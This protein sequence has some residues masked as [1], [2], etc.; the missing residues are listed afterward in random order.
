MDIITKPISFLFGQNPLLTITTG[1]LSVYFY[2]QK[3]GRKISCFMNI[4]GKIGETEKIVSLTLINEKDK[5]EAIFMV[6]FCVD[7]TMYKLK[8]FDPPL[9][10]KAN[11]AVT[12]IPDDVTYYV[13]NNHPINM[14]KILPTEGTVNIYL[15]MSGKLYRCR[16]PK[17]SSSETY[18]LEKN[19]EIGGSFSQFINN[20]IVPK[21][22]KFSITYTINNKQKTSFI[23]KN[24]YITWGYFPNVIPQ[25]LLNN[26]I[27]IETTLQNSSDLQFL[28]KMIYVSEI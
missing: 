16:N 17:I 21:D 22:A 8:K 25:N 10:L 13:K 23:L 6:S 3:L 15:T 20:Q 2:W 28:N 5:T 19:I 18:C 1:L 12:I 27:H 14:S 9:L 11:E 26:K 7:N 24:G 4:G